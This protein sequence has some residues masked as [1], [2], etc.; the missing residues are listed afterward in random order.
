MVVFD[1]PGDAFPETVVQGE[2]IRI[3]DGGVV[4]IRRADAAGSAGTL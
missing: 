2:A 4:A 3:G 1:R